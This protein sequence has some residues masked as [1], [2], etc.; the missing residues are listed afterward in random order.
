MLFLNGN[1]QKAMYFSAA[2]HDKQ[3]RKGTQK[4]YIIHP[5]A[6]AAILLE[7]MAKHQWFHEDVIVAA[8]LHDCLEDTCTTEAEIEMNFGM[9]V[10][11]LVM[12]A[13]EPDKSLSWKERKTHT[14]HRLSEL[15]FIDL[16]VPLAD[17]VHNL[18]EVIQEMSELSNP[19]R[20]WEKFNAGRDDQKWYHEH[21]INEVKKKLALK[22]ADQMEAA[23]LLEDLVGK[24]VDLFHIIF[25][26]PS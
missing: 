14:I 11:N 15:T 9:A 19:E 5:F 13:S 6:V 1:I 24:Y 23:A 8:L 12:N 25:H 7:L 2:R 18:S 17:K 16:L 20:H 22:K 26:D 3:Y 4:H 10:L 21:M